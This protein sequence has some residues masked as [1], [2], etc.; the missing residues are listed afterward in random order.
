[1]I[2]RMFQLEA[3]KGNTHSLYIVLLTYGP[4]FWFLVERCAADKY[5]DHMS[6]MVCHLHSQMVHGSESNRIISVR[7]IPKPS[8][9][10][11]SGNRILGRP[12]GA[13]GSGF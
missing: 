3:E 9:P 12:F 5:V 13:M 1:M 11:F 7:V 10:S 8:A 2:F 6:P 4:F